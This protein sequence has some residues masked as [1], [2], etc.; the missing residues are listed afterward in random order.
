MLRVISLIPILF[1]LVIAENKILQFDLQ[2]HP[3]PQKPMMTVS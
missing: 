1:S 3:V 2:E